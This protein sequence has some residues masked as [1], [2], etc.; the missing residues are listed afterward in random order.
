MAGPPGR[1]FSQV[2]EPPEGIT[3][4]LC[5]LRPYGC[6]MRS[7]DLHPVVQDQIAVLVGIP[8]VRE[9]GDAVQ[10]G[11][12]S[13]LPFSDPMEPGHTGTLETHR[14]GTPELMPVIRSSRAV[15]QGEGEGNADSRQGIQFDGL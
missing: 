8:I 3:Y 9:V 1:M 12:S 7:G 15:L 14:K 6:D 2:L 5:V 11:D 10:V 4:G 13:P